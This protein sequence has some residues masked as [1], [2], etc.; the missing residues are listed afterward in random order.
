MP[1]IAQPDPALPKQPPSAPTADEQARSQDWQK[2][3]ALAR[4]EVP[5]SVDAWKGASRAS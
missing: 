1:D 3:T 4:Q 5:T 2:L